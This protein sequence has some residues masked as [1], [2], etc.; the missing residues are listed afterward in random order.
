MACCEETNTPPA[1]MAD[2]AS[3]R[4]GGGFV[5]MD[6][7]GSPTF[8]CFDVNANCHSIFNLK[9][10]NCVPLKNFLYSPL[11]IDVDANGHAI[12]N[13]SK[14][15]IGSPTDDGSGA[16]LQVKGEINAQSYM[17][18][19]VEFA[20][21]SI[22]PTGQILLT[23]VYSI[24]GQTFTSMLPG[25]PNG[26]VQ[27]D[28]NGAF[29]GDASFIYDS[30]S[31]SLRIGLSNPQTPT[32]MLNVGGDVNIAD[33]T[34][35]P[36]AYRINGI[37]FAIA[38]ADGSHIDLVNISLING[39]PPGTGGGGAT[40]PA[41]LN[42]E[43]QFNG[44]GL[45]A[46]TPN[47][48]WD[49]TTTRLG[50]G[51]SA[52]DTNLTVLGPMAPIGGGGVAH[53]K[54]T[55][56]NSGIT[57]DT[58]GTGGKSS[59]F[60][61]IDDEWTNEIDGSGSGL[62]LWTNNTNPAISI[63]PAGVVTVYG[64]ASTLAYPFLWG[65]PGQMG[66]TFVG[67]T[68]L[69]IG[70]QQSVAFSIY[71]GS[72]DRIWVHGT[73]GNVGI[74]NSAPQYKLDVVGSINDTGCYYI[75]GVSFA[76]VDGTGIKLQNITT[77]NGGSPG[78]TPPAPPNQAIQWD[79]NG[80]FG[81]SSNLVWNNN[82]QLLGVGTSAPSSLIHGVAID[83]TLTLYSNTANPDTTKSNIIIAAV[84]NGTTVPAFIPYADSALITTKETITLN[85]APAGAT[86]IV[87]QSGG[88]YIT[89]LTSGTG[90]YAFSVDQPTGN[91]GIRNS[92]P[93]ATFQ[94]DDTAKNPALTWNN[95]GATFQVTGHG[96]SNNY[97]V[98][99]GVSEARSAAWMQ[100]KSQTGATFCDIL[101]QPLGGN[102]AINKNTYA[103][104]ALDVAGDI[105]ISG[106]FFFRKNGTPIPLFTDP[107]TTKGDL[108][109]RGASTTSNLPVGTN[110]Q[111]L[112]ADNT[113]TLGVK[114]ATPAVGQTQTPWL[115]NIS[116]GNFN[117][118]NV[119]AIGIG[120][121]TVPPPFPLWVHA[122]ANEN[123][124][125]GDYGGATIAAQNDSSN[126]IPLNVSIASNVYMCQS[127][128]N[129]GIGN[130]NPQ[131]RL[132]V[133]GPSLAFNGAGGGFIAQFTTGTG[134]STD[135]K[136]MFGYLNGSYGWIQ[137]A[138]PG[139]IT[140]FLA[141]NPSG[142]NVSINK[143]TNA[144]ALDITGDCNV[145]GVFRVNG[146]QLS[147]GQAQTPWAQ[148]INGN[149][150]ALSGAYNVQ[151]FG[152]TT[153]PTG[154]GYSLTTAVAGGS[155]G[156]YDSA[157]VAGAGGAIYFGANNGANIFA[158]IKA[159]LTNGT[160]SGLGDLIFYNCQAGTSG[161]LQ[162][163]CRLTAAG[164]GY[165][166][167]S[168]GGNFVGT[169]LLHL[170]I[171]QA[172]KPSTNAWQVSSD[173]RLKRNIRKFEGGLEIVN[174]L[175]PIVAE[176]NGLNFLPEG[177]RVVS[178]DAAKVREIV[179]HAVGVE[180]RRLDLKDGDP[181][182]FLTLNTHEIFYHMLLAIQQ[183]DARLKKFES[184]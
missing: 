114:W 15:I 113:Q 21:P 75:N 89:Y 134:I 60:F 13:L 72:Q 171:D 184:L 12:T 40:G 165:T 73:N 98:V 183:L 108:I 136:I 16:L 22:T 131:D 159:Y 5:R 112:T 150:F 144:Y 80:V 97:Q 90:G 28:N 93:T 145:T 167:F 74:S 138:K 141:L 118:T 69:G 62:S 67:V 26:A 64:I 180:P 55:Q 32:W 10:I 116:G 65:N 178:M 54:S 172:A 95:P 151:L 157:G 99:I 177:A 115:S 174:K 101:L 143:V 83:P 92:T 124:F 88:T 182:D 105:N 109:V 56:T 129:V 35:K 52:P 68:N 42:G 181:T 49:N 156:L 160:G 44:S 91:V 137:A 175:E 161:P 135:E 8:W 17:V 66:S 133:T 70:T 50:V 33:P 82:S 23:N 57:I 61:F 6:S 19:G 148:N 27:F 176:Y 155:L 20:S 2:P 120:S 7:P 94:I 130:T 117:L 58:T 107:T 103:S 3:T 31:H 29:G 154:G 147:T 43:I 59:I 11:Q 71:T 45:F 84:S 36:F 87:P 104:Y 48:F 46:A 34:H 125:L 85:I 122:L 126:W 78:G 146:T 127:A 30:L 173:I 102:I 9:A 169:S 106:S 14:V 77:I 121:T 100:G 41:G 142:G 179:P 128:G 96:S 18:N 86:I 63:N 25:A 170:N 4:Q 164:T 132:S 139:S 24:N 111:V 110:N 1:G 149:G 81:G 51:T 123:I 168:L 39:A 153:A 158:A 140:R 163:M 76:C 119:S 37:P 162:T 79:N 152:A 38:D 166:S 47:L 53:F